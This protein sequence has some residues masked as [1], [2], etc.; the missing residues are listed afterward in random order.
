MIAPNYRVKLYFTLAM[1]AM[2][3][4]GLVLLDVPIF[5]EKQKQATK[6][7]EFLGKISQFFIFAIH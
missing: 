6:I 4:V 7:S 1:D 3:N 5:Q 2:K